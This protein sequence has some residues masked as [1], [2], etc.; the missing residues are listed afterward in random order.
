MKI[1]QILSES[2]KNRHTTCILA[3][4]LLHASKAVTGEIFD[5][6]CGLLILGN[7]VLIGIDLEY[8]FTQKNHAK[9]QYVEDIQI[10]LNLWY[11]ELHRQSNIRMFVP[12]QIYL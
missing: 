6:A 5:I 3:L 4:S 8:R 2:T 1:Y 10:V 11:H 7:I 9:I 12:K